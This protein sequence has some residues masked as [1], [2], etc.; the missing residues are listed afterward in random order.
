MIAPMAG[1]CRL[2]AV[3]YSC[4]GHPGKCIPMEETNVATTNRRP[5]QLY[6][7]HEIAILT[8]MDPSTVAKWIDKG[9]LVAF[10]TPGRHRRVREDELAFFLLKY[11]MPLPE[12]LDCY[13]VS[14]K[15][16]LQQ[17]KI[18]ALKKAEQRQGARRT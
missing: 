1:G 4:C 14:L 18:E 17:A 9:L 5:D 10:R 11:S 12:E 7:T 8:Q 15:A 3:G 13:R 2:R 6:T 16:R